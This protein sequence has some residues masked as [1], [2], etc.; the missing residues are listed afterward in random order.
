MKYVHYVI[1][2]LH[3]QTPNYQHA[4]CLHNI[5]QPAHHS[6]SW[7]LSTHTPFYL[8][9]FINPHTILPLDIYQPAH[10]STSWYLSTHQSIYYLH[11]LH[12]LNW[13]SNLLLA[14]QYLPLQLVST[15]ILLIGL[16]GLYYLILLPVPIIN[17]ST[18]GKNFVTM[19]RESKVTCR[20][21][22]Q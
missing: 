14:H 6:T 19:R 1:P 10:H 20:L 3:I 7:Y 9:I 12:Y 21:P 2:L 13:T 17:S 22:R 8:L 11:Q 15:S 5:Y 16:S 4:Q 18:W